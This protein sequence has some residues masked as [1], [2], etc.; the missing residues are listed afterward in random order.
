MRPQM[1]QRLLAGLL[2]LLPFAACAEPIGFAAG[3]NELYRV[4]LANGQATRLGAI[5][6]NGVAGLATADN[7]VTYGVADHTAGSGSGATDFLIR[8]DP[9]NGHGTLVGQLSGLAGQGPNGSLDYGLAVTCDG[10]LW[11]SSDTLGDLWEVD[12]NNGQTRRVGNIG[13]A[14]SGLAASGNQLFGVGVGA[15]PAL[16]RIDPSNAQATRIGA[17]NIG[18]TIADA[19]LDFD[20]NGVL[21][22]TLDPEPVATGR[23]RIA[24]IDPS[25]G[26]ASLVA[27]ANV[28]LGLEALTISRPGGC[29]TSSGGGTAGP[30]PVAIPGPGLPA[31]IALGLIALGAGARRLRRP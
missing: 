15:Q 7:G 29:G 23:S 18:G 2:S 22:A 8:I 5:G 12:R 3:F 13:A 19:G 27:T 30:T 26:Q 6:F 4:D 14:I 1:L 20:A 25:T 11:L 16:Y 10:R 24:R 9:A 17:L 28:D 31:L 21:W